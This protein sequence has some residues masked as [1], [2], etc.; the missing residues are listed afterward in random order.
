MNLIFN[1]L[2][3]HLSGFENLTGVFKIEIPYF[4]A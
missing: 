3:K 1:Q 4:C 2:K